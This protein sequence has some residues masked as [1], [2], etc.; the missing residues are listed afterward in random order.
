MYPGRRRKRVVRKKPFVVIADA[1]RGLRISALIGFRQLVKLRA[2][3]R[4][5]LGVHGLAEGS[6]HG[7]VVLFRQ[8]LFDVPNFVQLMPMSA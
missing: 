2:C 8:L 5:G 6:V 4:R 1:R 3:E 7:T